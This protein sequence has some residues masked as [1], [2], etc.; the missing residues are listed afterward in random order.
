MVLLMNFG[1]VGGNKHKRTLISIIG[2][3]GLILSLYVPTFVYESNIPHDTTVLDEYRNIVPKGP[4][5]KSLTQKQGQI[6]LKFDFKC[7]TAK[8]FCNVHR[9]LQGIQYPVNPT[10]LTYE[11]MNTCLNIANETEIYSHAQYCANETCVVPNI[12]SKEPKCVVDDDCI[13]FDHL[14]VCGRKEDTNTSDYVCCPSGRK[15]ETSNGQVCSNQPLNSP[16]VVNGICDSK[17]CGNGFCE[18]DTTR[19][20][21]SVG[22]ACNSDNNCTSDFCNPYGVCEI[23][24][25]ICPAFVDRVSI[26]AA[27]AVIAPRNVSE[28]EFC[29]L[30]AEIDLITESNCSVVID[31]FEN[32]GFITV[33]NKTEE[34][35]IRTITPHYSILENALRN[36]FS[37]IILYVALPI[38]FVAIAYQLFLYFRG[39]NFSH[40]A[41]DLKCA[42]KVKLESF[43]NNAMK[44]RQNI[45]DDKVE[46]EVMVSYTEVIFKILIFFCSSNMGYYLFTE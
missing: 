37:V 9:E 23:E 16:C 24:P 22:G 14:G 15:I 41:Y 26:S 30:N 28:E 11:E 19:T 40:R 34:N 6:V 7:R 38:G 33:V 25:V 35:L 10:K 21:K 29:L 3:I 39:D 20:K 32:A 44:L 13:I 1:N 18:S 43:I 42:A 4:F 2:T 45:L 31:E 46:G 12:P 27:D 36:D 17:K 5:V 8:D